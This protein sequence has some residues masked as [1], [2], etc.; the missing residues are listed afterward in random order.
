MAMCNGLHS[1]A[2]CSGPGKPNITKSSEFIEFIEFFLAY[3][4]LLGA[5][6]LF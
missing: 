6:M 2:D 3:F 4:V 1:S 5:L